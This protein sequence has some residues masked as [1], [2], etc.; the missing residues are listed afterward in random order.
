ML[1]DHYSGYQ[2]SNI[3]IGLSI[4]WKNNIPVFVLVDQYIGK[5]IFQYRILVLI[6]KPIF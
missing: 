3:C 5:P 2:Y 4:Y 1:V 6:A